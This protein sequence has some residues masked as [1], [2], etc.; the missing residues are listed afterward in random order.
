ML[1]KTAE[2]AL[3]AA[4]CLAQNPD[5]PLSAE[6]M[7]VATRVPR[8]YLHRVLQQMVQAGLV[9]SQSGPN[10]GY[11][12]RCPAEEIRLIDVV[13]AFGPLERITKC[14]LGVKSHKGL[15]ALHRAL[16]RAYASIEEAFSDVTV[17]QLVSE[18]GKYIPLCEGN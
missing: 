13:N 17:A 14:P 9:R 5:S 11:S 2:Y 16:D 6:R 15:C 1:Q 7:A 8:R 3:R 18:P 12:L 4:V 10:G